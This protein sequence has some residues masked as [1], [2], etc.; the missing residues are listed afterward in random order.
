LSTLRGILMF[1]WQE[2]KLSSAPNLNFHHSDREIN[3][4]LP[5]GEYQRARLEHERQGAG[6]IL[7][8]G[9]QL[10]KRHV[11]CFI[12]EFSELPVGDRGAVDPKIAD[13]D[14]VG[15]RLFRIMPVRSHAVSAAGNEHPVRR[16]RLF[17]QLRS[18][19]TAAHAILILKESTFTATGYGS[20]GPARL[21]LSAPSVFVTRQSRNG[22]NVCRVA[23]ERVRKGYPNSEGGHR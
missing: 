2:S 17:L 20:K 18:N 8:V 10:G 5:R 19:D 3:R 13:G 16:R 4:M 23:S 7:G 12:D 15:R 9:P 11:A 1:G 22:A 21:R 6:I 14:A